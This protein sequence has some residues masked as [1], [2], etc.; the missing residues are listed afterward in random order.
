[1][2]TAVVP[3]SRNTG[4][5]DESV[6]GELVQI[7]G[8]VTGKP[9]AYRLQVNDG[10]GMVE[11]NRYFNLGQTADPNYI[12]FAPFEVGDTV[13][14]VGVTRGYTESFG[15]TREVLPRGPADIAE[16]PRALSVSPLNNATDVA[17][18]TNLT[19]TF[20]VSMTNVNSATFTLRSPSGAVAGTVTYNTATRT[21]T[22]D[23]AS[24]LANSTRYTATLSAELAASNGLTLTQNYVW[25]FTTVAALPDLS[26]STKVNSVNDAVFSGTWV[27]Y[28]IQ[29][30]NT[31]GLNATARVTDVLS[32]YYTVAKLLDFSQPTTGTLT[33]TGVVTA[34]QSVTLHFVAQVKGVQNLPRGSALLFNTAEVNDGYQATFT[35]EDPAPPT[36]TIYG[37]YLPLIHR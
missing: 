31:G 11:V 24:D 36:I 6:E 8:L 32:S 18:T 33:W 7:S 28:T 26:T 1:M 20:N 3:Q 13:R 12:D 37:L 30:N 29:L 2:G 17:V 14:V 5:I 23:P 22:F 10:S 21:A 19:A 15:F 4:S 34:G 9:A 27:T 25:S 35:V 16:Y